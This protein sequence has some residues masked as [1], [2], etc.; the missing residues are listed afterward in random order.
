MKQNRRQK[1]SKTNEQEGKCTCMH[2]NVRFVLAD[3][4]LGSILSLDYGEAF[5][6]TNSAQ[7]GTCRNLLDLIPPR[8][9]R[10]DFT[11]HETV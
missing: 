11:G 4:Q 8:K 7:V 2:Q 3:S 6:S 9:S 5:V 10:S 1:E